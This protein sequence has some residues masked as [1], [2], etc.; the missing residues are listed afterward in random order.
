MITEKVTES[1]TLVYLHAEKD[2]VIRDIQVLYKGVDISH[3]TVALTFVVE[4]DG[5]PLGL[6]ENTN[7]AINELLSHAKK[8]ILK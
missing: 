8:V 6:P 7:V 3:A 1:K 2:K 4:I 5:E